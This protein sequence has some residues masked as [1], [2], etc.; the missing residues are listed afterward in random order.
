MKT[1]FGIRCRITWTYFCWWV[2]NYEYVSK[3]L[4]KKLTIASYNEFRI[5]NL[6]FMNFLGFKVSSSPVQTSNSFF[7]LQFFNN[8]FKQSWPGMAVHCQCSPQEFQKLGIY[9]FLAVLEKKLEPHFFKFNLVKY[10]TVWLYL[11]L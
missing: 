11:I 10:L 8:F 2:K 9:K 7:F 4:F 1:R 5:P 6:V 3:Y